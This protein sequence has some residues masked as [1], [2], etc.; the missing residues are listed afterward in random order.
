VTETV[1]S[2]GGLVTLTA[3]RLVTVD[4]RKSSGKSVSLP[5]EEVGAG[6]RTLQDVTRS[7]PVTL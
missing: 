2:I 4:T 1:L 3:L 5:E 7:T 6:E